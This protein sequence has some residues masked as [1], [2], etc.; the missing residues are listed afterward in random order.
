MSRIGKQP[1]AVPGGVK[2][3]VAGKEISVEG[4]LGKLTWCLRPEIS[5][6]HDEAKK[7]VIVSPSGRRSAMACSCSSVLP[8]PP[9]NTVQPSA[10]APDSII[11]PP[12]GRW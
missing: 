12:G 5:A 3:G 7:Q 6:A 1:V 10:S 2:I 4:P 8:T 9:G 11:S